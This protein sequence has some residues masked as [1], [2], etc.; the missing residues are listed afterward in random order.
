AR[1]VV[2]IGT[3]Y[4]AGAASGAF[5]Y[6]KPDAAALVVAPRGLALSGTASYTPAESSISGKYW[7]SASASDGDAKLALDGSIDSGNNFF[8]LTKDLGWDTIRL[9]VWNDPKNENT[10]APVTT[11]GNDSP[12]N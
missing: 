12:E 9:R 7:V 10:G 3:T 8:G 5:R 4:L 1:R 11:A 2:L 6:C